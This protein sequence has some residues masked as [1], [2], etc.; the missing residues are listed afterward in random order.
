MLGVFS[1][2]VGQ[3][4]TPSTGFSKTVVAVVRS[5]K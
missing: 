1:E 5:T 4:G 2:N 3:Q